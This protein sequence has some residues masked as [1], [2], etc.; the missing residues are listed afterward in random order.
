ME[1]IIKLQAALTILKNREIPF[2]QR[3]STISK[4]PIDDKIMRKYC[5]WRANLSR[6]LLTDQ[7]S[8]ASIDAAEKF[9]NKTIS[10]EELK[11]AYQG[12]HLA[13]INA[14]KLSNNW[15]AARHAMLAVSD[16]PSMPEAFLKHAEWDDGWRESGFLP[17]SEPWEALRKKARKL[18]EY[19]LFYLISDALEKECG[20]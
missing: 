6:H 16:E 18:Q 5:L 17:L 20:N 11:K 12:A 15:F 4:L 9:I 7:R 1:T 10:R 3:L 13:V 2:Y 19:V 8:L 14:E